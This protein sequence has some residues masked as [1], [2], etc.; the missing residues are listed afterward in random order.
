MKS[1]FLGIVLLIGISACNQTNKPLKTISVS[2]AKKLI[3]DHPELIIVDVRSPDETVDGKLAN[4][5]EIDYYGDD[6]DQNLAK[7]DTLKKY[8]VYC[9]SGKRSLKSCVTMADMGFKDIYS[10]D[11]GYLEWMEEK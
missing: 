8:L 11:G 9:R 6:F 5:I 1:F 7:L 3:S 10:M 4:A 2:Q